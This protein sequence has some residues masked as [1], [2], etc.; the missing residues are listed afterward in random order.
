MS[1]VGFQEEMVSFILKKT[2]S[3]RDY[4]E[5]TTRFLDVELLVT[6]GFFFGRV[7]SN[8]VRVFFGSAIPN[9]SAS[10]TNRYDTVSSKTIY[11]PDVAVLAT[12]V[13]RLLNQYV[14]NY[15][16]SSNK[17]LS[18]SCCFLTTKDDRE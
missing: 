15:A 2:R 6:S 10:I 16:F 8:K 14:K 4:F 7:E 18:T 9:L 12:K 13:P 11:I 1:R 17:K 3:G 5:L